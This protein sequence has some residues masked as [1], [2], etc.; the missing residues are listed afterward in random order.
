MYEL[1]L[2]KAEEPE[3]KLPAFVGSQRKQRNSRKTSTSASLTTLKPLTVWITTNCGKFLKTLEDLLLKRREYHLT[4]LLRNIYTLFSFFP[5]FH[6]PSIRDFPNE[7]VVHIQWPKYWSFSL[8]M[9]PSNYS[10]E[11]IQGW[12]LLRLMVWSPCYPRDSQESFPAPQL[13]A[14]ILRCSAFLKIQLSQPYVTTG[15]TVAL[16]IW[17]SVGRVMSLLFNTLSRAVIAFLPRSKHL[18]SWL[19]SPSTVISEPRKRKSVSTSTFSPSIFHEV[20]GLDVMILGF[21]NI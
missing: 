21:F 12:F 13:K 6:F 17:T 5:L 19:Q 10:L 8:G 1:S 9:S 11:V 7:S 4:C 16:T 15:K 14:S 18:I 3:I 2:E 20:M